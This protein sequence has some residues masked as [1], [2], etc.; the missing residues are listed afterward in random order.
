MVHQLNPLQYNNSV[1]WEAKRKAL[2]Q[3][4]AAHPTAVYFNEAEK[5]K[6]QGITRLSPL[7][8]NRC[9]IHSLSLSYWNEAEKGRR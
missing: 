5:D 8:Y 7:Q 4:V 9:G 2:A 1:R 3:F 6:R